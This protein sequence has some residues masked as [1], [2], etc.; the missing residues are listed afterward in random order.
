[1]LR[2]PFRTL[3]WWRASA[4]VGLLLIAALAAVLGPVTTSATTATGRAP[5]SPERAASTS[6]TVAYWL[7]AADGGI[8]GF[9]APEFGNVRGRG[10]S[11][12]IVGMAATPDGHGYWL[13]ASDGGVFT[14]GDAAYYGSTGG[15]RLARPIVGMAATPDGHGYWL[16]ASDGG[17][18][19]FG[20]AAF[21]GSTGAVRLTRPIVGMAATADG[22]GYWLVASDGGI[23]TFGDAVFRGSAGDVRLTRPVVG[24]AP[25]GDGQ[26]Y[27]LVASDG[28]IFTYGDAVFRGS[29]G[30]V[31]LT[32]PIVGMAANPVGSGYWLVASDGGVF[33]FGD[34]PYLG[35]TGAAPGPAPVVGIVPTLA[36]SLYP[37]GTI[38]PPGGVGTDISFPQCTRAYPAAGNPISI[39]GVNG[40]LSNKINPCFVSE[41]QWAGPNLTVYINTDQ[42]QPDAPQAT[43]GPQSCAAGDDVCLGYNWGYTN[44]QA[45]VSYVHANGFAP[46]TWWLDVEAPCGSASPLWMCGTAGLQSNAAVIQG[47]LD[48]LHGDGLVAGIYSTY[49]QWPRITGGSQYPG[50][51]IWIATVPS[52]P[53]QWVADCTDPSLQFA[54]GTPYL[55]QWLGGSNPPTAP[56]DGDLACRTT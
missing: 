53:V 48:A 28:G 42:V 23:F 45:A 39:V 26:G 4:G 20:D 16:V 35:S 34:A 50:L 49:Y 24:M 51:P 46:E 56:Y 40:G 29:T 47:A 1:M 52:G 6:G 38:Y 15:I 54:G 9:H 32:R 7:A 30:G 55:I 33:P 37:G 43:G 19:T 18:F 8:Y 25:T 17:V 44:A 10:L 12:P 3:R 31:A 11:A 21:H 27:W 36:G 13:V 5:A 14:F 2:R 41:A 22:S